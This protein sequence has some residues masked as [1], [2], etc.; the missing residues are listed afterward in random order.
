[1]STG[2][3]LAPVACVL[4]AALDAVLSTPGHRRKGAAAVLASVH[5]LSRPS[6]GAERSLTAAAGT[7]VTRV[8]K[9][10]SLSWSQ[11]DR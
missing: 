6:S 8:R 5:V 4:S 2:G 10:S 3:R 9:K 7:L 1:M 11:G